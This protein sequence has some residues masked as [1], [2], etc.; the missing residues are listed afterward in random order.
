MNKHPYYLTIER[1]SDYYLSIYGSEQM[2]AVR[3]FL[4]Q[5]EYTEC[6]FFGGDS[7]SNRNTRLK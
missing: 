7:K 5:L 1:L 3:E 4:K 6:E 2:N